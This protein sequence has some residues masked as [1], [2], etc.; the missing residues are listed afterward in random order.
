M[1]GDGNNITGEFDA[2]TD[3]TYTKPKIQASGGKNV[4]ILNAKL[5]KQLN[6]STPLLLRGVNEWVNE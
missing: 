2:A 1:S 6:L 5:S 3:M 4:A